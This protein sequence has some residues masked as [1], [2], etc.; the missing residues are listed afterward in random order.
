[1]MGDRGY[2]FNAGS[3]QCTPVEIATYVLQALVERAQAELN[4]PIRDVVITVPAYFTSQQREDTFNAGTAAGLKV[5][6]LVPE[7]TAAAIAYA[8]NRGKDQRVMVYDLGGGTFDVSILEIRG[9]AF[10]VKAVGGDSKL[11]GDDFDEEMM[12]WACA[13]IQRQYGMDPL[14]ETTPQT[15]NC[16]SV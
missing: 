5:L 8:L 2:H 1:M 12:K 6:R 15:R 10:T 16:A 14:D 9:N 3:R 13:Q 11:G 4:E 7:P